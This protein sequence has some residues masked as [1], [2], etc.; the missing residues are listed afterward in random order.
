M[1]MM[2][3]TEM[4]VKDMKGGKEDMTETIVTEYGNATLNR[5]GYFKINTGKNAGKL[6]HRV[7]FEDFYNI[8]LD[9]EFIDR[10]HI[11]HIDHNKANNEIWNLE[12]II[13]SE[14]Q[15]MHQKGKNNNMYGKR[16][17]YVKGIPFSKQR[18]RNIS[19]S[20]SRT[21]FFRVY[22]KKNKTYK[23]G[24]TWCYHYYKDSEKRQTHIVSVDLLKLKQKVIKQGLEWFIV[25]EDIA[26]QVCVKFGY[27]LEEVS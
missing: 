1:D 3:N 5:D 27:D 20:R 9:D 26:K 15:S 11:H 10:V 25:N 4:I 2:F 8:N 12:P 19:K 7:I 23:Q 16:N 18:M 22:P 13:P 21:G 6:L 24:F 14:H 17:D